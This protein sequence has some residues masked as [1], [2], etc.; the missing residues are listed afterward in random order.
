MAMVSSQTDRHLLIN[1]RSEIESPLA[2]DVGEHPDDGGTVGR[3]EV[4]MR[5]RPEQCQRAIS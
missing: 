3:A 4:G 1:Q 2:L 5:R